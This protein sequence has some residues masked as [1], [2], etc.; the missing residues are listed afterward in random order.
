MDTLKKKYGSKYLI[1]DSTD[2]I[3]E[4]LIKYTK[5]W[6]GIKNSIEK[7]NNKL[8]EYGKDF[9]KINFNS[10]DNLPLNKI[11]KLHNITIT[12]RSVFEKDSK[13]YPQVFL[14]ECLYKIYMLEY[15]RIDIS[16]GI[17]V[18][19]TNA[20]KECD[21]CHY[22]YF[23]DI[24]FK[25]D[26]YLCNGCHGLMQ[27]DMNFNDVAI[28]SSEGNDYRIQFRYMSKNDGINIMKNCNLNEKSG[29]F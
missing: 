12:V 6:D 24:G 21:I 7:V 4:V 3:K 22:W 16:E 17:D 2:K 25:Y 19:K 20:S 23:K 26:P 10:D 27:R 8:G 13:Y 14:D 18:N 5:L 1:L 28:V 11:L 15:D 29:S 9:I